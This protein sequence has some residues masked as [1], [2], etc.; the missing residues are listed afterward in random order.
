M[1]GRVGEHRPPVAAG[2]EPGLARAQLQ[3]PL[4]R[5]RH[6]V[7]PQVQVVAL[8]HGRAGPA[9]PLVAIHPAEA[10]RIEVDGACGP[11]TWATLDVALDKLGR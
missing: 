9:R 5:L 4:N 10:G 11:Q 6:I 8:R 2:L 1:P 3:A 7:H